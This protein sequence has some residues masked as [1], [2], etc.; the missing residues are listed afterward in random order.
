LNFKMHT[1]SLSA[2]GVVAGELQTASAT[3]LVV[4]L[5]SAHT[6]HPQLSGKRA[7]RDQ[8]VAIIAGSNREARPND[9][10]CDWNHV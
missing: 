6:L 2:G 5:A 10:S 8:Y 7:V 4:Q 9:G 3:T 1:V